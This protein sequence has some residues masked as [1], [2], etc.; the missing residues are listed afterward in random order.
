MSTQEER[1]MARGFYELIGAAIWS[2]I[3]KR[4]E[5][6]EISATPL[7]SYSRMKMQGLRPLPSFA[8]GA[9]NFPAYLRLTSRQT[10]LA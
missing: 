6:D 4:V 9:T 8:H 5:N 3:A 10:G 7:E 2:P 1:I